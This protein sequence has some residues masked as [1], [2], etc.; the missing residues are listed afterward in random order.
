M[1]IFMI[2]CL[3]LRMSLY[4]AVGDNAALK[5]GF[6]HVIDFCFLVNSGPFKMQIFQAIY[7][8]MECV[9]WREI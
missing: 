1:F 7:T 3:V 2:F 4:V 9:Q 8:I 5:F 6:L